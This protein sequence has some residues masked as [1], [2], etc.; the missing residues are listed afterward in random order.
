M[1]VRIPAD[2]RVNIGRNTRT[3]IRPALQT[4]SAVGGQIVQDLV[5]N[6]VSYRVH[7]FNSSGI[8]TVTTGPTGTATIEYLVVGGGAGGGPV[9]NPNAGGG[10][11]GGFLTGS[12]TLLSSGE[13]RIDVGT[14]GA[15]G[16]NG[17]NSRIY[18]P[19]MSPTEGIIIAYGGGYGGGSGV[20]GFSGGSGGGGGATNSSLVPGGT[21]IGGQGNSGGYGWAIYE[22]GTWGSYGSGGG[23]GAGGAGSPGERGNPTL[24]IGGAARESLI[25]GFPQWY[26]AGG[27][28]SPARSGGTGGG[29]IIGGNGSGST[30]PNGVNAVAQT[31]SGGGGGGNGAT[32]RVIIRYRL[33]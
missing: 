31:G 30:L 11:A 16:T 33:S 10:G 23:G 2:G 4:M 15:V 17:N 9:A 5:I 12:Y 22:W 18:T 1:T 29:L 6:G 28:A 26:S 3:T 24:G 8:L 32:G 20:A 25:N 21:G 19:T 13:Y 27:G 7:T 14:G